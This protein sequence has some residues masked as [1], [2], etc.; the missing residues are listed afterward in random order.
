M[1]K[2]FYESQ[3]Q[4]NSFGKLTLHEEKALKI[5]MKT[6]DYQT[7]Y[8]ANEKTIFKKNYIVPIFS[9]GSKLWNASKMIYI[10]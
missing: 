3:L 7:R 5:F 6:Q 4:N 1:S 2:R 10:Y 9:Y 8:M